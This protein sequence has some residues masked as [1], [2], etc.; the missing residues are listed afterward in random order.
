VASVLQDAGWAAVD[1]EDESQSYE[2]GNFWIMF[3]NEPG[4]CMFETTDM[5]TTG[6]ATYLTSMGFD[7]TG[8]DADGCPQFQIFESVATLT[9]GGN[10]P[11]CSSTTEATFR[12]T[13]A[14]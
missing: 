5:N 2:A 10:D 12:F 1:A 9:G 6:A 4:F 11:Q 13:S 7:Q 14:P 3:S 8:T